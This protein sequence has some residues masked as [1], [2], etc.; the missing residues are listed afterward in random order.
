MARHVPLHH[1]PQATRCPFITFMDPLVQPPKGHSRRN[2]YQLTSFAFWD[3][4]LTR[5]LDPP[6]FRASPCPPLLFVRN[7]SIV[8]RP[9]GAGVPPAVVRARSLEPILQRS[10]GALSKVAFKSALPAQPRKLACA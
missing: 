2:S 5:T 1:R 6:R 3:D 7:V 8:E 10:L 9:S 4:P